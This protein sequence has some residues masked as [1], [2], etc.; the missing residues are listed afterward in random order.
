MLQDSLS[1]R[2]PS[3]SPANKIPLTTA[4]F[5]RPFNANTVS[6]FTLYAATNKGNKP[7]FHKSASPD[8]ARAL[9]EHFFQKVKE[10]C[11]PNGQQRVKDGVFQAMMQ[12]ALVN[13]GPVSAFLVI[14][15]DAAFCLRW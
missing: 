13:D 5:V 10:G 12:V 8:Q 7:S 2:F 6:Q 14:L 11:G 1:S 3:S 4:T 15:G 9:Y